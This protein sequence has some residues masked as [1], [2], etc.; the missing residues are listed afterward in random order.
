MKSHAEALDFLYGLQRH[1]I[2]LGLECTTAMLERLGRPDRSFPAVQVAGTNGKGATC[3]M[4]AA[5]LQAAGFRVGLYT[6]PHLLDFRERIR[7][8]GRPIT[9]EKIVDLVERVAAVLGGDLTPTFFEFTTVMAF[10]HFAKA[11]VDIG[12]CEVGMGGRFDATNVLMPAAAAITNVSLDHEAFLGPTVARIAGEKAGIVKPGVPLVTGRLS[13]EAETVIARA[14]ME[15]SAPW[16]RLDRDFGCEGH[17]LTGFE[18]RGLARVCSDLTCPLPGRH[19]LDNAACALALVELLAARGISVSEHAI[20]SGLRTVSWEGRLEC[21]EQHPLVLLDGA[22]NPAAAEALA[23][24]LEELRRDRPTM[25]IILVVGMM[26]DK[27][28]AG[29]LRYLLPLVD[30]VLVTQARL[31]RAATVQEMREALAQWPGRV[32]E[33]PLPSDA[34]AAARGLARSEDVILI[35]GSLILVGEVKALLLGCEFSPL[36][37]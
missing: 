33:A 9:E 35:T 30:E 27:D 8:D 19:Q 34:L 37:G 6:S 2:R 10:L 16:Y 26:R 11:Q 28:R 24:Y 14:A 25:R 21:V 5:V 29:F 12:V 32:H 1:G 7:V 36:R 31:A 3:A 13:V 4:A 23:Q 15:R 17:S 20:R 18:Y 22:H